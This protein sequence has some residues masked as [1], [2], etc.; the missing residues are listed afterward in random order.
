MIRML[1]VAGTD[2]SGF[3]WHIFF[4][5]AEIIEHF[6]LIHLRQP[7]FHAQLEEQRNRSGTIECP[8][9]HGDVLVVF[10][11][12]VQ[13]RA[14]ILA[15]SSPGLLRTFE[16]GGCPTGPLEICIRHAYERGEEISCSL[17]THAAMTD[18]GIVLEAG[19]SKPDTSTLA[20]TG[21]DFGHS[22]LLAATKPCG[23]FLDLGVLNFLEENIGRRDCMSARDGIEKCGEVFFF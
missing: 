17:L 3:L 1:I 18:M 8:D 15:E 22:L 16:L 21:S 14:A 6:E 7:P 19:N 13:R 23:P 5:C 9:A 4:C 2:T 12:I 10:M 20:T 11:A